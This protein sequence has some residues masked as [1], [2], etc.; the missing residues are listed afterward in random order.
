MIVNANSLENWGGMKY[1]LQELEY[2]PYQINTFVFLMLH[3]ASEDTALLFLK[4]IYRT[5]NIN[6]EQPQH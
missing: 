2:G 3:R 4:E 5:M 1:A 6:P